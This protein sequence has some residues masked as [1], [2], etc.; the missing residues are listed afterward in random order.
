MPS[1][2]LCTRETYERFLYTLT[3]QYP[4]IRRS[5]LVYV[6][7]GAY[8]GR[9]EGFLLFDAHIVLC[10]LEYLTF[11]TRGEIGRYGMVHIAHF[12]T[13]NIFT[14]SGSPSVMSGASN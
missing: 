8:F 7:S 4:S 2:P 14:N 1:N 11:L 3:A 5:T 10:V 12:G 13:G 6:P 9:V